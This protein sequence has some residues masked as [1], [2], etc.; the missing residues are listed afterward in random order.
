MATE[1][2]LR[3]VAESMTDGTMSV[4]ADITDLGGNP[5]ET[6][7]GIGGDGAQ[8]V[9]L[10]ENATVF[11]VRGSAELFSS[12]LLSTIG[13]ASTFNPALLSADSAIQLS[14][15]SNSDTGIVVVYGYDSAWNEVTANYTLTGITPVTKATLFFRIN[16][17]QYV[18][19]ADN[20]GFVY[21]STAGATT[22][23]GVPTSAATY[24]YSMQAGYNVS[25]VALG[26]IPPEAGT[27]VKFRKFQ[28]TYCNNATN[29]GEL[30]WQVKRTTS[31]IW[32]TE[33]MIYAMKGE[34]SQE[35]YDLTGYPPLDN[36]NAFGHDIRVVAVGYGSGAH[37]GNASVIID[38]I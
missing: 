27:W 37:F 4:G 38:I 13:S 14:S 15:S 35:E 2:T 31:T 17:L 26:T 18:G 24:L 16:R 30:R 23:G 9:Y 22:V 25:Q 32:N 8:R 34:L 33:L 21:A 10:G 1:T 12:S 5:I 7:T 28:A 3:K 20:L 6:N 19:A 36:S 11:Q 29:Y